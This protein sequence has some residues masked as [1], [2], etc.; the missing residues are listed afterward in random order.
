MGQYL[1]GLYLVISEPNTNPNSLLDVVGHQPFQLATFIWVVIYLIY[2]LLAKGQYPSILILVL[3]KLD[4]TKFHDLLLGA[5][6]HSNSV[7]WPSKLGLSLFWIT[8][9]YLVVLVGS[10]PTHESSKVW[11]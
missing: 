8:V 3:A 2:V 5:N 4:K 1:S 11:L 10:L 7:L 6:A 9:V